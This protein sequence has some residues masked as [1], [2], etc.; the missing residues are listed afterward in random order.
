[1]AITIIFSDEQKRQLAETGAMSSIG[2]KVFNDDGSEIKDV[3]AIDIS[4]RPNQVIIAKLEVAV[5]AMQIPL[6]MGAV[7]KEVNIFWRIKHKAVGFLKRCG[8]ISYL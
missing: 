7:Y 3:C 4:I 8:I 6:G 1:M 2:T 5:D